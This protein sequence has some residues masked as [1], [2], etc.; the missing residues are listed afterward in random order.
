MFAGSSARCGLVHRC[1]CINRSTGTL[2]GAPRVRPVA[3]TAPHSCFSSTTMEIVLMSNCSTT[4]SNKMKQSVKKA[5][6]IVSGVN[7]PDANVRSSLL[8]RERTKV[9]L[10]VKKLM[11]CS[12]RGFV[13]SFASSRRRKR[14][15]PGRRKAVTRMTLRHE[16]LLH[17]E[18]QISSVFVKSWFQV[19]PLFFVQC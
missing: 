2:L 4:C 18:F 9:L 11:L 6:K 17:Q 8:R 13:A 14:L 12:V 10:V 15:A 1:S 19:L 7:R 3:R 5:S 16:A